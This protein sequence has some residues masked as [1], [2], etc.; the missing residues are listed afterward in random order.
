M[1]RLNKEYFLGLNYLI[2]NQPDKAIDEFV[3]LLEVDNE[4]IE[5]H[6]TLGSLFRSRGE[7]DRAIRIHQNIMARPNL[8]RSERIQAIS[9]LGRDYLQAGVLD[10]A[11]SL[12]LEVVSQKG[13]QKIACLEFLL[14][15]YEQES[16]WQKAIDIARQLQSYQR[17]EMAVVISQYYCELAASLETQRKR[18]QLTHLGMALKINAKCVRVNLMMGQ[19]YTELGHYKQAIKHLKMVKDQCIDY[20]GETTESLQECY[21]QINKES[22]LIEYWRSCLNEA[23]NVDIVVALAR[24]LRQQEGDRQ[25][26]EFLAMRMRSAPSLRIIVYLVDIYIDNS[27]G[28]AL[29]KLCLLKGFI[30]DLLKDVLPY[31]CEKCGFSG[32]ILYWQCPGCRQW[33]VVKPVKEYGCA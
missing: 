20:I 5:I 31:Q 30:Q 6:L 26:I 4:T 33:E 7:V 32:E 28:D 13:P 10:R 11:E 29:E 27:L 12:F 22:G 15:I 16:D 9:E 1:Q 8:A 19:I 14:C 21:Q 2:E 17:K 18:E 25:A 23:N 24:N 3:K